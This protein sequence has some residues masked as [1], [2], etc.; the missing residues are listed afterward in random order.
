MKRKERRVEGRRKVKWGE[1]GR[2]FF[3]NKEEKE[4]QKTERKIRKSQ[5]KERTFKEK[6]KSVHE[7][8]ERAK[9]RSN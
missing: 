6:K 7:V 2:N 8:F 5:T 1:K 3:K 4:N 9:C